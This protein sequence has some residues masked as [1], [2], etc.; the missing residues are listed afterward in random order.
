MKSW[1]RLC[2]VA[3]RS[4]G[5]LIDFILVFLIR[6]GLNVL[7]L[8]YLNFEPV[9]SCSGPPFGP[10]DFVDNPGSTLFYGSMYF[11]SGLPEVYTTLLWFLYAFVSIAIFRK[12]LGMRQAGVEL[13]DLKGQRPR[14]SQILLRQ[15][16]FPVSSICWLG[17]IVAGF[18]DGASAFHDLVS[19]T[20]V[21]YSEQ[22]NLEPGDAG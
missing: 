5:L 21:V 7:G 17:Y 4:E 15:V 19:R 12:T 8:D 1:D 3:A 11:A 18:S 16:L 14:L 22:P 2:L 13:V 10:Q 20:R 6:W 9:G